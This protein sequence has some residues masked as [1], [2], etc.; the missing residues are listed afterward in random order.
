MAVG[1]AVGVTPLYGFHWMI[2]VAI[3]VP[4]RLDTGIALLASQISLPFI[5]PFLTFAEIQIG[6]RVLR[7]VWKAVSVAE[8]RG[9]GAREAAAV[10]GELVVGTLVVA[11]CIALVGG[12]LAWALTR[13]IRRAKG[14]E[15]A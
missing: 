7:G 2:L 14:N 12:T 1:L 15:D 10:V 6:A 3:C 9:F 11:P 4:F 13:A 5:A 8:L